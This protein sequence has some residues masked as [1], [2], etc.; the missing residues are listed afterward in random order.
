MCNVI[1]TIDQ[2]RYIKIQPNT[3]DL[4]TRLGGINHTNSLVISQS[5]VP[6]SFRLSF[7]I[8]KL[9]YCLKIMTY[10]KYPFCDKN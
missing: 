9:V 4:S 1:V 8:S 10:M 6:R 7:N 2:F 5:L 3:I